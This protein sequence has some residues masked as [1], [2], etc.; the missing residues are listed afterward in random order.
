[1]RR[2]DW[3]NDVRIAAGGFVIAFAIAIALF[4][5][6]SG[7]VAET[8]AAV[9][10]S[11]ALS[12]EISDLELRLEDVRRERAALSP[13][14]RGHG[15]GG[16]RCDDERWFFEGPTAATSAL[17]LIAAAD[18]AGYVRLGYEGDDTAV[19]ATFPPPDAEDLPVRGRVD[20][21][22]WPVRFR[23]ETSYPAVVDFLERISGAEPAFALE[24]LRLRVAR[25]GRG[26]VQ[27]RVV[28]SG[29][30]AGH[31]FRARE[32]RDGQ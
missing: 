29:V 15:P 14:D 32:G 17:D 19:P 7:T 25:D 3:R 12:A 27:D 22:R 28:V 9:T 31:W 30:L 13:A 20:I 2:I 8:R 26:D 21:V 18:L 4:V 23:M 24:S 6:W 16:L 1:M 11:A 5:R 10:A